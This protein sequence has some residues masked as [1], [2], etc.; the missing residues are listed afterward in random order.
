MIDT[1]S[2][3]GWP[4]LHDGQKRVLFE[5]LVH[6]P[7]S[8]VELASRLGLSRTSLTRLARELVEVGF[9]E[10]GEMLP[11]AARGRPREMLRLRPGSAHFAGIKLTG[12]ALYAVA[13]DLSAQVVGKREYVLGSREVP[14]VVELIGRVVN[15]MLADLELPSAVGVSLA[16]DVRRV[17]G[18]EF[19]DRSVFL[20][21]DDVPLAELVAAEC[22]LP[23][24][25]S[26]DVLGLTAAHH[27]F[28]AGVGLDSMALVGVGAGVRSGLVSGGRLVVGAHGTPGKV[29]HPRMRGTGA[30]CWRG[31]RDC[32]YSFVTT[33][34]IEVNAGVEPGDYATAVRRAQLG[35]PRAMQ[36]FDDAAS[37][38]GIVVS[39]VI[40]VFDPQK[41]VITGEG[42]AM[43]D[44]AYA[45]FEEALGDTCDRMP[46]EGVIERQPFDFSHYARGAAINALRGLT[47]GLAG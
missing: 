46:A 25:V 5:I 3:S 32:V 31:H 29:G 33:P 14:D 1:F 2:N 18:H 47:G 26:N 42:T 40:N 23:G 19:V 11:S 10:E 13:T 27:W 22:G 7:Q 39:Q 9:V 41:V 24:F 17:D 28:G 8:R 12:D 4:R 37:A 38:L 43:L 20:G 45:R 15:E 36:A 6:G 35:D 34:A 21:W 30:S 16:G 44:L